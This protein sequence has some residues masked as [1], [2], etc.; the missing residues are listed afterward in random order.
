MPVSNVNDPQSDCL[1]LSPHRNDTLRGGENND[2][3]EGGKGNDILEGGKGDD[4]YIFGRG[5]GNDTLIDSDGN[6]TIKFKAGINKDD[7]VFTRTGDKKHDLLIKIKGSNDSITVKDMFKNRHR[8]GRGASYRR[9]RGRS[10]NVRI[11]CESDKYRNKKSG[12]NRLYK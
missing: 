10:K 1:C 9:G 12:E 4:T 7:L 2:I 5:D 11:Q 3:L 8:F 6:D